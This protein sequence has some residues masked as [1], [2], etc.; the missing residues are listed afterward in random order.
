[1]IPDLK[2]SQVL[3]SLRLSTGDLMARGGPA[4]CSKVI[5]ASF[6]SLPAFMAFVAAGGKSRPRRSI[7]SSR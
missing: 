5:E 2:A 3:A 1:M 6:E 4:P 7:A